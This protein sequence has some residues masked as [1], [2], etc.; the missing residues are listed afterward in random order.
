MAVIISTIV[1]AAR[2]ERHAYTV[3]IYI[4][5]HIYDVIT[6]INRNDAAIS[7]PK[8]HDTNTTSSGLLQSARA[9]GPRRNHN[10]GNITPVSNEK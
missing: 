7:P 5:I 8:Q 6:L 4:H 3:N 10:F 1:I 2:Y 9:S